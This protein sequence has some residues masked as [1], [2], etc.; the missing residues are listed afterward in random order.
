MFRLTLYIILTS[1]SVHHTQITQSK[2]LMI[3]WFTRKL[4]ITK[5]LKRC[6]LVAR[7]FQHLKNYHLMVNQQDIKKSKP[8]HVEHPSLHLWTAIRWFK[9]NLNQLR[10][11][12]L[13]DDSWHTLR[14][15]TFPWKWLNHV[16]YMSPN[17]PFCNWQ[18]SP[19][20]RTAGYKSAMM[21]YGAHK[22]PDSS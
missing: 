3:S 21:T 20:G 8:R 9:L 1:Q 4:S 7:I 17:W 22:A 6:L 16:V 12:Y 13:L 15:V 19:L 2:K 10:I 14:C 18:S 11:K 5:I